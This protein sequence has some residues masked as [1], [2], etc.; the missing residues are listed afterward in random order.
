MELKLP[1]Q[2]GRRGVYCGYDPAMVA[3][4]SPPVGAAEI[5]LADLRRIRRSSWP[6]YTD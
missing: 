4:G 1:C 3:T 6:K 5:V 2:S